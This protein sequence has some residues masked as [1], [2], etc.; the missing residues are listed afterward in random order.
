MKKNMPSELF[1][2]LTASLRE[3]GAILQGKQRPSRRFQVKA[4]DV[5][6]IRESLHLSQRQFAALMGIS[7]N[8]LQNW[9]QGRRQPR[10]AAQV[11]LRVAEQSPQTVLQAA[12]SMFTSP[13]SR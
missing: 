5:R 2:E 13:T 9:E 8:T 12:R 4:M 11:L 7:V 1:E 3:G 10:G 6:R